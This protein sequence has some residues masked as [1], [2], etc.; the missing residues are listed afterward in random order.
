MTWCHCTYF[1]SIK[2]TLLRMK[3]SM[4]WKY[5][6]PSAF[7]AL[8][9][10]LCL[11]LY[12]GCFLFFFFFSFLLL[13]VTFIFPLSSVRSNGQYNVTFWISL[14]TVMLGTCKVSFHLAYGTGLLPWFLCPKFYINY[15]TVV[16]AKPEGIIPGPDYCYMLHATWTWSM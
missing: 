15:M 8:Y 2:L 1:V 6:A 16:K 4:I 12:F 14:D 3:Y 9:G 10:C 13:F 7:Y 5:P 11:F